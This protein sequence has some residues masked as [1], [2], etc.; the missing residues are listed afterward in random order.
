MLLNHLNLLKPSEVRVVIVGQ[1]PYPTVDT[2]TGVAFACKTM[3]PS[4]Y[5]LVKEA[6]RT[7]FNIDSAHQLRD[8]TNEIIKTFD[9]SLSHWCSQGVLL[10]NA[11]LTCK[12]GYPG[13]H[14][15]IWFDFYINFLK[16]LNIMNFEISEKEIKPIIFVFLGKV[17]QKGASVINTKLNRVVCV[18]HPA[19]E[20]Y[21]G[22][23]IGCNVF[24]TINELLFESSQK[25]I[26]WLNNE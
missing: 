26:D 6:V 15:K 9:T 24:K 4:L 1:D 21:G 19:A 22:K 13:S 18:T 20:T 5:M 10:L 17:S 2:A 23:F 16:S 25:Q 12:I 7:E 3:Q 14:D 11:S 8:K